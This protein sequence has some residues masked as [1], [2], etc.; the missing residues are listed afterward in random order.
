MAEATLVPPGGQYVQTLQAV[1]HL[2]DGQ[3]T[4]TATIDKKD[5]ITETNEAN[6]TLTRTL[7][8]SPSKPDL[9]L[10]SLEL[11]GECRARLTIRNVGTGT[12]G[13][14]QHGTT[15]VYRYVDGVSKGTIRLADM[16]PSRSAAAPNGSMTWTDWAE[17]KPTGEAR[18]SVS[19]PSGSDANTGNNEAQVSVPERCKAGSSAATPV[20]KKQLIR[21]KL[22]VQGIH[23]P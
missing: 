18:Y 7:S 13:N 22:P 19:V 12:L 11:D 9:A 3:V 8:C 23:K 16:D 21:P 6:N 17:F 5:L 4:F 20:L 15:L 1:N 10:V 14:G 2:I